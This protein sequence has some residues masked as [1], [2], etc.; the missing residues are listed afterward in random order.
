ME[1]NSVSVARIMQTPVQV[2]PGITG[3]LGLTIK[4]TTVIIQAF[5]GLP[6]PLFSMLLPSPLLYSV[7]QVG[8]P[9]EIKNGLFVQVTTAE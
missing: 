8:C 2:A 9:E 1:V 3:T 7:F 6:L 4:L 5:P